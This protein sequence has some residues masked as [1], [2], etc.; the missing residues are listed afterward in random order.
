MS[1]FTFLSNSSRF[2]SNWVDRYTPAKCSCSSTCKNTTVVFF[3]SADLVVF[4][5]MKLALHPNSKTRFSKSLVSNTTLLTEPVKATFP[6]S[7]IKLSKPSSTINSE[8]SPDDELFPCFFLCHP[9]VKS[10]LLVDLRLS[11][12]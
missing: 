11:L 8:S 5:V 3:L 10:N 1:F 6:N 9:Q 4:L 12:R 2:V 7:F